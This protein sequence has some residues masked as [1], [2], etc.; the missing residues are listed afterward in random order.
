MPGRT[1]GSERENRVSRGPRIRSS[2]CTRCSRRTEPDKR[3][4]CSA[5]P[6]RNVGTRGS[7]RIERSV[8]SLCN[9]CSLYNSGTSRVPWTNG[10]TYTRCNPGTARMRGTRGSLRR[11]PR[12]P[13]SSAAP[14]R[15]RN[16]SCAAKGSRFRVAGS[17]ARAGRGYFLGPTNDCAPMWDTSWPSSIHVLSFRS[18]LSRWP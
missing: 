3:C 13:I 18:P 11:P 1:A 16:G 8:R 5:R 14:P 7:P 2:S 12:L 15:T 9:R 6:R 4:R 17:S 10:R